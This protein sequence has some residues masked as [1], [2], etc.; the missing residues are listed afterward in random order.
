MATLKTK[1]KP[2]DPAQ[3]KRFIEAA[4]AAGVDE[5]GQG[6]ARAFE[7]VVPV[8]SAQAKTQ[9]EPAETNRRNSSSS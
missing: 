2:D 6:F 4:K 9:D 7:K 1:P 8:K 3:S 5:T